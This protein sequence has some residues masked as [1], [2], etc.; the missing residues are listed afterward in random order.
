MSDFVCECP[1]PTA[2]PSIPDATCPESYGLIGKIF[3]GIIGE[4]FAD[5]TDYDT[6]ATWTTRLAAVDATK[7]SVTPT[8]NN[9][10]LAQSEPIV[11]G[12]DDNTTFDGA[13]QITGETSVTLE[14]QFYDLPQ[15]QYEALTEFTCEAAGGRLGIIL[16][17]NNFSRYSGSTE[18]DFIKVSSA[19]MGT[20]GLGGRTEPNQNQMTITLPAGWQKNTT[21]FKHTNFNP[22]DLVNP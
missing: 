19:F 22:M 17:G 13:P 4:S 5:T 21:L 11:F 6:E 9:P 8:F 18:P 14:I 20:V 7:L 10:A 15:A 2:I 16:A 3:F 1:L 12:G